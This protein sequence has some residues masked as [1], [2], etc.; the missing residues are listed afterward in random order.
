MVARLIS[1]TGGNGEKVGNMSDDADKMAGAAPADTALLG[2]SRADGS[3]PNASYIVP[4]LHRGLTILTLF[5][6]DR[7]RLSLSEIARLLDLP[8]SAAFRLVYTLESLGFLVRSPIDDRYGLGLRVLDLGY[9][10]F[11]SMD[12][13]DLAEE[14]LRQLREKTNG[15]VHLARIDGAEIVY[16]MRFAAPNALSSN[17]Q[18]GARLPAY[19]TTLGRALLM[20]AGRADLMRIFGDVTALPAFTRTTAQSVEALEEQLRDDQARGYVIGHSIY[21]SGLDTMAAPIRDGHDRI[22]AAISVV[23]FGLMK[24]TDPSPEAVVAA[25]L[26]TAETIHRA[27]GAH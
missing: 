17:V 7:Q 12:V 25:V 24:Q 4:G 1:V 26:D 14:P 10:L 18:I 23:G 9:T 21:E 19:A 3:S 20:D 6:R 2:L 15:S 11:N 5:R 27:L 16:L 22:V 8:R 13:V